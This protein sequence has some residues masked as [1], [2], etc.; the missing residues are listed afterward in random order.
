MEKKNFVC[1][2]PNDAKD[3]IKSIYG[4]DLWEN[5]WEVR[6]RHNTVELFDDSD[7]SL[8]MLVNWYLN[9]NSK[10]VAYA[11]NKLKKIFLYIL[12]YL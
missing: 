7:E 11:G 2:S 5:F 3:R 4:N 6:F 1:P 10:R 8:D 12:N 9:K